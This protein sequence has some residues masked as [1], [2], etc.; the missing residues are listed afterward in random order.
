MIINITQILKMLSVKIL[1]LSLMTL[2]TWNCDINT[3]ADN[4]DKVISQKLNEDFQKVFIT[5]ITSLDSTDWLTNYIDNYKLIYNY[6]SKTNYKPV[7]I[8]DFGS[9][10]KVNSILDYFEQADNHGINPELYRIEIIK[11]EISSALNESIPLNKRYHHLSN[12]EMI[13]ANSLINYSLHLRKGILDPIKIFGA[14]Y[15]LPVK[16]LTEN[17][18]TEVLNKND[19]INYLNEIQPRNERYIRLQGTLKK[20]KELLKEKWEKIPVPNS[21]IEPGDN[22]MYIDHIVNNLTKLGFIDTNKI[23]ISNKNLY[24][25]EL[26]EPIKLFQKSHG[27]IEDGIIG[28]GTIERL[29]INPQKYIEKIKLNLERF[30]WFD[31]SDTSKYILVN[32]PDFKLMIYENNYIKD[33]IKVCV[34]KKKDWQTPILYGRISHLILNPTWTVPQRIIQEEIIDGLRKDSLYLKKK[35]FKAYKKGKPVTIDEINISEL[36]TKKYTLI[37][38]PGADNALGKIKFMFDNQFSIYLHDTPK[39]APFQQANRAVSHGCIRV[40]KPFQLAGFLLKDNSDWKNDYIKIETGLPPSNKESIKEYQ[41]FRDKLRRNYSFGK[42][43]EVRL[44]NEIPVFIDYFTAW[45]D[46]N[47]ILNYRDDIYGKDELLKKHLIDYNFTF[48]KN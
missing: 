14:N 46:E 32:I 35:N 26:V 29:N 9:I 23:K 5:R 8:K 18:M 3:K 17:D 41:D 1:I 6:Y 21:K 27:L 47:G 36:K 20:F 2:L 13:L 15:E 16:N 34:G 10:Q 19:I 40:E 42:T 12:V 39:R 30:R 45:V 4:P 25:K 28:K 43:T 44:H 38:D 48:S 33:E 37:Q 11:T 7:L 24:I 31:Y 22:F